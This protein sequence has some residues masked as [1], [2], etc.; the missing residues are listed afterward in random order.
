MN[1]LWVR[2]TLA[3][4]AITLVGIVSV[5]VLADV[6]ANQAFRQYV[7]RQ[8]MVVQSGLLDDLAIFYQR[9]GNW[10]GVETVFSSVSGG[11]AGRGGRGHPVLLLADSHS[12]I[13]YDEQ[14]I[15][16]GG[17]LTADERANALPVVVNGQTVGYLIVSANTGGNLPPAAQTFLDQLR[18]ALLIVVLV[19]GGLGTLLAFITSRALTAPLSNLVRA[20]RAFAARDWDCRIKVGGTKEIAEV[21]SAFNEMAA[22]IQRTETLRRNLVADIAHEL[23]T[24]L[25]VM[26]G[27]LQALLDEV[28]PL[29]RS[30]IATLYDESRQLI[31]MVD[32]LRELSLVDAGQLQLQLQAVEIAPILHA[33]AA[34]FAIAAEAQGVRLDVSADEHLPSVRTD[35]DR[36]DQVV[37]NLLS[38]A[39]RHTP[40]GGKVHL[41]ATSN[42]TMRVYVSDTGEGI[43]PDDITHVFERFYR[44]DQSR[45]RS[46]GN[47]GLGLA[48]C[49]AWV[50]AMGGTVG[51]ES[52]V[53]QGSQF[54][55]T[56]PLA[57][58]MK[59]ERS[60][61]MHRSK[62]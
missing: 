21:G 2:L 12:Q 19:V 44:A 18:N 15:R 37:R 16:N 60:P 27:S 20:A 17:I 61:S 22:E 47:T 55:F 57:R 59:I 58:D 53:G 5:A 28:Y 9:Q 4:I 31:R 8:D 23:R 35:P 6:M 39:L 54:W 26:Q 45:A 62:P 34:Q 30:E 33:A 36:L 13:V 43:A 24:P 25:T 14:A 46:Q 51:V 48:I 10:N 29:E 7:S 3:F 38:N 1:R 41:T 32:D 56:L 50:E 11:G 40:R 52:T 42:E 49:K